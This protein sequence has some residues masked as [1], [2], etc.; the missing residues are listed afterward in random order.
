MLKSLLVV[1]AAIVSIAL[2][3]P[4]ALAATDVRLE[5]TAR[6]GASKAVSKYEERSRGGQVQQRFQVQVE[7]M[8]AGSQLAVTVNGK[9]M[10]TITVNQFG[11][12]SL[13]QR[14]GSDDPGTPVK[15]LP[16]MQA[17]DT[18]TVGTLSAVFAVR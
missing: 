11:R 5:A 3:S 18:V 14:V 15:S 2:F 10:G 12:G 17:G 13:D 9:L 7:R 8:V 16:H 6:A 4:R 1:L